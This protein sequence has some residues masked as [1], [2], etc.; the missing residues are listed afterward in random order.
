MRNVR[1]LLDAFAWE[2][3]FGEMKLLFLGKKYKVS[4]Y[5]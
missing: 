5:E 1:L 4:L 2:E 3:I